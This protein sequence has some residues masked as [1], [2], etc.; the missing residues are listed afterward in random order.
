MPPRVPHKVKVLEALEAGH[1][2]CHAIEQATGLPRRSISDTLEKLRR[3]GVIEVVTEYGAR[4]R[5]VPG[6]PGHVYQIKG[7]A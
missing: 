5:G 2:H 6:R 1:C 4:Q 7:R 3:W